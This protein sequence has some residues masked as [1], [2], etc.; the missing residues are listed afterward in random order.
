MPHPED[1]LAIKWLAADYGPDSTQASLIP[2]KSPAVEFTD[3]MCVYAE[4][5]V[6]R[7][8]SLHY[9]TT[10][11]INKRQAARVI[12]DFVPS[13]EWKS[14]AT[15]QQHSIRASY[16]WATS[17]ETLLGIAR[18]ETSRLKVPLAMMCFGV[19]QP[20]KEDVAM[21]CCHAALGIDLALVLL[22][23][24]WGYLA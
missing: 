15:T 7:W 13:D 3:L 22:R 2:Y 14:W 9:E 1:E 21:L 23:E 18:K 11:N 5:P 10:P 6:N 19:S 12:R 17:E 20:D 24:A 16:P 8:I 4:S